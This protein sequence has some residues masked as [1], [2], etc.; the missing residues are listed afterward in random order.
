M[1]VWRLRPDAANIK[2]AINSEIQSAVEGHERPP[3]FCDVKNKKL[4]TEEAVWLC[5]RMEVSDWETAI[6]YFVGLQSR[7]Y[8]TLAVKER[9]CDPK[10]PTPTLLKAGFAS[11]SVGE[12]IQFLGDVLWYQ[13]NSKQSQTRNVPVTLSYCGV[14][15]WGAAHDCTGGI[16]F[17]VKKGIQTKA[18]F[19]LSYRDEYYSIG[20]YG[21]D[22][23]SLQVMAII[24]QLINLNKSA[25]DLRATPIVQVVP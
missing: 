19:T 6:D 13:D 4:D 20:D 18:R 7:V 9:I 15:P 21:E 10:I 12:M 5:G 23:H 22:D 1:D 3:D 25:T 2:G 16:L 8:C 17:Q 14:G 11:R 24:N